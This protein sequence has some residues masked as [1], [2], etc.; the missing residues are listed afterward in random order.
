[1]ASES[2]ALR[3][4]PDTLL[5]YALAL[6]NR[7]NVDLF[8]PHSVTAL[9]QDLAVVERIGSAD[10]TWGMMVEF[11][12]AYNFLTTTLTVAAAT[13]PGCDADVF[14]ELLSHVSAPYRQE[15]QP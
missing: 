13:F 12:S 10:R 9:R 3:S 4:S 15:W 11:R 14:R 1:V 7:W 6:G 5:K 2:S 8:R